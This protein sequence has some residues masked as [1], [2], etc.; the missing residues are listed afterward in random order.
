M[1][2]GIIYPMTG[3]KNFVLGFSLS[4]CSIALYG[5]LYSPVN[6][7]STPKQSQPVDISLYR[8]GYSSPYYAKTA[9][10]FTTISRKS[11]APVSTANFVPQIVDGPEDDEILSINLDGNIPIE[12][13]FSDTE[14]DQAEVL[15]SDN[16]EKTAMLPTD[17][18]EDE[19]IFAPS[20]WVAAKGSPSVKNKKLLEQINQSADENLFTDKLASSSDRDNDLSYKVAE[21]IKQSII[22]PIPDEIL[23]DENLT[24]TFITS[25]QKKKKDKVNLP[26]E[27]KKNTSSLSS[28]LHK[29]ALQVK[30]AQ[31][32]KEISDS[33]N[34]KSILDSISSWFSDKPSASTEALPVQVKKKAPPAYS[35]QRSQ[36]PKVQQQNSSEDL[37]DFYESLQKVKKNHVERKVLPTELKLSFQ[38]GRAEISGTTLK[39]LKVFSEASLNNTTRIQILLDASASAEL[40]KK[41]LNLLYT[42]FM[43]NG[44]DFKKVDT[45]FS[46]TEPNT[47]IIRTAND[48]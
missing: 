33:D 2:T 9:N 38:P 24:P 18:A 17:L 32:I 37:A 3:I 30:K 5:Q 15:Q 25:P 42:I 45:V 47:F 12:F 13:S 7:K 40:Q 35:S 23:N 11:L 22:F 48:Q 41:R 36:S 43:N 20:P 29:E 8:K 16:D 44:V 21:K 28:T 46:L 6:P 39:W 26:K 1:V 4:L 10:L 31:P 19:K 14:K 27:A 34:S